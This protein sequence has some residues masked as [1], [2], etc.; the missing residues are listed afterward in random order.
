MDSDEENALMIALFGG[1]AQFVIDEENKI[2]IE[3]ERKVGN[4]SMHNNLYQYKPE[5][6]SQ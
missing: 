3:N 2:N 6:Q 1:A 5:K 4:N